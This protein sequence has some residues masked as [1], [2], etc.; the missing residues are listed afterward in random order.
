MMSRADQGWGPVP[1]GEL[2][3]LGIRL[4]AKRQAAAWVSA[5]AAMLAVGSLALSIYATASALYTHFSTRAA[6][7]TIIISP[8]KSAYITPQPMRPPGMEPR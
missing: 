7:D 5:L 6:T 1:S 8:I 2:E 4:R 3:R